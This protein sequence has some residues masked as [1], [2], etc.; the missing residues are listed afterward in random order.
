[1][2]NESETFEVA[3][4]FAFEDVYLTLRWLNPLSFSQ[5]YLAINPNIIQQL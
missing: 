3:E 4:P 2:L 1:M 5:V